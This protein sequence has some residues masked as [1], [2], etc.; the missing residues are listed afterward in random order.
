MPGKWLCVSCSPEGGPGIPTCHLQCHSEPLQL[1]AAEPSLAFR[2]IPS[3]SEVLVPFSTVVHTWGF[4]SRLADL[5][6][7]QISAVMA[8]PSHVTN[9]FPSPF[10]WGFIW[11]ALSCEGHV[12]N[13]FIPNS[14][15]SVPLGWPAAHFLFPG[16]LSEL[17]TCHCNLQ[18]EFTKGSCFLFLLG[19]KGF[20]NFLCKFP[21]INISA[22]VALSAFVHFY[23]FN[24]YTNQTAVSQR[25]GVARDGGSPHFS[26]L[27]GGRLQPCT[28]C[29]LFSYS[30]PWKPLNSWS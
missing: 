14:M 17:A 22:L 2:V 6:R 3:T 23:L 29:F 8:V 1:R 21:V 30:Q 27:D 7:L 15:D 12:A 18:R 4:G 16:C 19:P 13:W 28:H 24:S 9:P 26:L 11:Q 10:P 20:D 5:Q 25:T